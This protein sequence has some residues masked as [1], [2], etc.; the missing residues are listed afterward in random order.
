MEKLLQE[1]RPLKMELG[2]PGLLNT[3]QFV[4][5]KQFQEPL[6]GDY[7]EVKVQCTGKCIAS[8][9]PCTAL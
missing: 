4:D 8:P 2:E 1:E 7:V 5:D 9:L 6:R 3:F